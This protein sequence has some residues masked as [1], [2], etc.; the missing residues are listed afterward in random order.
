MLG[1][2]S[3]ITALVFSARVCTCSSRSLIFLYVMQLRV[4]RTWSCFALQTDRKCA[5]GFT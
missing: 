1:L 5:L 2:F 4:F 3:K